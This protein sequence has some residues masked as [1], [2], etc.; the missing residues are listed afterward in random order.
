MCEALIV[1]AEQADDEDRAAH[2]RELQEEGEDQRFA[3]AQLSPACVAPSQDRQSRTAPNG[4]L[5]N[6][7]ERIIAPWLSRKG[8]APRVG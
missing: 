1:A 3:W 5:P 7:A 8:G 2:A 6:L 4:R